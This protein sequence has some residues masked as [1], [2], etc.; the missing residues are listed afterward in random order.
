MLGSILRSS[1]SGG[2]GRVAGNCPLWPVLRPRMRGA[3]PS[4]NGREA[5]SERSCPG[6]GNSRCRDL[7]QPAPCPSFCSPPL[8]TA[9]FSPSVLLLSR[10]HDPKLGTHPPF[11][12]LDHSPPAYYSVPGWLR[13]PLIH[14]ATEATVT[15]PFPWPLT[16]RSPLSTPS[17]PFFSGIFNILIAIHMPYHIMTHHVYRPMFSLF[18]VVQPLGGSKSA[19]SSQKKCC[20]D[21]LSLRTL[22]QP[23]TVTGLLPV[24]RDL[25]LV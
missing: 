16:P 3:L 22:P 13:P 21:E 17:W 12:C 2:D 9:A 10:H 6:R 24:S 23:P 15:P 14:T 4:Q 5:L 25:P 18:P 11:L 19:F 8:S 7:T 20:A 1:P